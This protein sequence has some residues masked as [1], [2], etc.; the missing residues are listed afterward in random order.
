MWAEWS[1][2]P[3]CPEKFSAGLWG[4]FAPRIV[5]A[6]KKGRSGVGEE[7]NQM[8]FVSSHI[9]IEPVETPADVRLRALASTYEPLW[10]K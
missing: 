10:P 1:R 4:S 7:F 8:R 2:D 6:G 5:K 3:Q 9:D